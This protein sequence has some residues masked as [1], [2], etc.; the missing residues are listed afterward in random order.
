LSFRIHFQDLEPSTFLQR[1]CESLSRGLREEFPETTR[2]EVTLGQDGELRSTQVHVLGKDVD[3]VSTATCKNAR[4][5]VNDAFERARRQ[6][7]K[8]HDKQIFKLRRR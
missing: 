4:E 2:F 1:K 6:L 8:H 7:R 5:S 3:L